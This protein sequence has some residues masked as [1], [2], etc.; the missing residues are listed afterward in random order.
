MAKTKH[1][2]VGRRVKVV[3]PMTEAE[4]EE[5]GWHRGGKVIVFDDKSKV[6]ASQDE[7]GNDGGAL[8]GVSK[9]ESLYI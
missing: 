2:L 3:R 7:E 6:Y 5:E 4:I 9:G 8:F 1:W